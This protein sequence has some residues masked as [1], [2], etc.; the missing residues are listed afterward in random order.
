MLL[1]TLAILTIII[2]ALFVVYKVLR[3][4]NL[5]LWIMPYYLSKLKASN[6]IQKPIHIMFCFVDHYEPKWRGPTKEVEQ[7]RVNRWIDEYPVIAVSY[8]HLTLPT[9]PYV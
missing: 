3:S 6:R 8:T 5:H 7:N 1:Y 4:R 2:I 9:T